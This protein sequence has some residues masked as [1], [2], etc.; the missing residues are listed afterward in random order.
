M[1]QRREGPNVVSILGE[2]ITNQHK[3]AQRAMTAVISSLR[4][5][6]KSG[7]AVRGHNDSEGNLM[8]LLEERSM[9]VP[10]LGIWL[11]K[12]NNRLSH[13][14]QNEIIRIMAHAVQ[15]ELLHDIREAAFFS[16]A[17]DGTTDI[18]GQE[19]FCL[20]VR[21]VDKNTLSPTEVFLG[22]YNPPDATA[23]SLFKSIMDMLCSLN[24]GTANL[25]GH[26]FEGAA[27][28]S[29]RFNGVQKKLIDHQEKSV[30]V[31]CSNHSLDLVLQEA[32]RQ[33]DIHTV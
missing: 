5:L 3:E 18:V 23:E 13:D 31:H 26:C 20:S 9:D 32:A 10:K 29:G 2:N 21:Y 11:K 28:M 24:I 19:Q 7:Q 14:I 16:I 1:I 15:R 25:R 27:N 12:R 33:C 17:A 22:M 6:C 8:N 30:Y 4:Y